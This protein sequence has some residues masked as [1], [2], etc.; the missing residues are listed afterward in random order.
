MEEMMSQFID[1]ELKLDE[2]IAFVNRVHEDAG[3]RDGALRL[4]E[5][6]RL[7]R[8]D[9]VLRVPEVSPARRRE[10]RILLWR[11]LA[12]AAS[13][14]AAV[15]LLLYSLWAPLETSPSPYRFVVFRPD[16]N[17]VEIAGTFSE[18]KNLPMSKIGDTG[19]WEIVLELP[20]GEHRYVYILDGRERLP[21]PTML[22]READDFG[23][24]NSILAFR[25]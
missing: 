3:F 20:R 19:Y 11:P 2:K 22:L 15:I 4:L 25:S 21:D 10:F 23:G 14:A 17:R 16:V 1:D 7:I 8:S 18:W 24:E 6:E 13:A 12:L 9:V 5:Q